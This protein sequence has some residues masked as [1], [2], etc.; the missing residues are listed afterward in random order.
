MQKTIDYTVNMWYNIN[1][2]LKRK[3]LKKWIQQLIMKK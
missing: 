1:S 3:R 2:F